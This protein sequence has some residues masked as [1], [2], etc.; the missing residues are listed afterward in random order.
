M[1]AVYKDS[2]LISFANN[3]DAVYLIKR[4]QEAFKINVIIR[5]HNII[6]NDIEVEF[7]CFSCRCVHIEIIEE[8]TAL[9]DIDS[10][11]HFIANCF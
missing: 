6:S 2:G 8:T 1:H 7:V 11:R 4:T 9:S 5:L 10:L 3:D